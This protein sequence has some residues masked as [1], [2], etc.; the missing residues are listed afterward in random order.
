M[1]INIFL[2]GFMVG[3]IVALVGIFAWAIW[4]D[5]KSNLMDKENVTVED[6]LD[7]YHM[8]GKHAIINDGKVIGFQQEEIPTQTSNPSGDNE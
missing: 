3:A 8:K 5:K 1:H 7:M 6:C 2:E 4:Y